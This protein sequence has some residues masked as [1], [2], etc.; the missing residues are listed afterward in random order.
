MEDARSHGAKGQ[1]ASPRRMRRMKYTIRLGWIGVAALAA[2]LVATASARTLDTAAPLFTRLKGPVVVP[3]NVSDN[4]MFVS[5]MINGKG[6]FRMIVDTGASFTL[7][8]PEVANLVG[9]SDQPSDDDPTLIRNALGD[10]API[11]MVSLSSIQI[12]GASFED[13]TA[14]VTDAFQEFSRIQGHHVDGAIGFSLFTEVYLG[15]DFQKQRLLID[16]NWPADLPPVRADLPMTEHMDVP[17][18]E[19]QIQGKPVDMMIDTGA[20]SGLHV[21][22]ELA[23]QLQWKQ[24]PR[25]GS[26]AAVV[27]EIRRE[28]IGRLAGSVT[29]GGVTAIEPTAVVYTGVPSIGLRS[30]E[31]FCVVF[32]RSRG[33]VWLCSTDTAPLQPIPERSVGLSL[34][35]DP[36][37]WRIA[38]V[39]PGSPAAEAHLAAGSLVTRIEGQPAANWS[40]DRM[41]AWIDSHEKFSFVVLDDS[42][43]RSLTLPSWELVP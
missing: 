8:S 13:V 14:G 2:G 25:A 39:I 23:A 42:G 18:V 9:A 35:F 37:G 31:H 29:L 7:V 5:V 3:A 19:V 38:S 11:R 22:P 4:V 6:P 12:G 43:E 30:L 36:D 10:V 33:R 34:Y 40:R 32:S 27:D 26:M 15:V 41:Q 20:N 1:P 21:S 24:E 17:F 28:E 16:N